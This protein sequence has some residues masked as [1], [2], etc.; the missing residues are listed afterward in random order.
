MATIRR[1]DS[2]IIGDSI[3][4]NRLR[5]CLGISCPNH[6]EQALLSGADKFKSNSAV[7]R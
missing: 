4:I 5:L 6:S 3:G 7:T 1:L 2:R